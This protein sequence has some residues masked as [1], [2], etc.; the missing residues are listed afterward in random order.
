MR[1][2]VTFLVNACRRGDF[3]VTLADTSEPQLEVVGEALSRRSAL[4][5]NGEGKTVIRGDIV[6]L[7][8]LPRLWAVWAEL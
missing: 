1:V 7:V 6:I 3:T 2:T 8:P 4:G 5:T